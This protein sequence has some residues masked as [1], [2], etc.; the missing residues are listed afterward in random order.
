MSDPLEEVE[1]LA[2]SANRIE[3]LLVLTEGA[4]TRRELGDALEASQPTLGRI[5]QDLTERNWVAYDGERYR[6]TATGRLVGEGMTDLRERLETEARFREVA[7]WLPN[8]MG[9]D[10]RAFGDATVTLPSGARP[11]APIRRMVELLRESGRV[12]LLSHSFN[13]A[14]LDLLAERCVDGTLVAEGVFSTDAIDALRAVPDLQARLVRVLGTE[15]AEIRVTREPVPLAVEV[16]DTRTHLLLRD[17]EG[18]VRASVDTDAEAVREWAS[19]LHARYWG[20]ARRLSPSE[21]E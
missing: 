19:D 10:L 15:G 12:R 5:L 2:R 1:F 21:S 7:P 11:N 14:K 8:E 16:T 18:L 6:A 9:V 3:V 13:E 20:D 4:Y 17:G